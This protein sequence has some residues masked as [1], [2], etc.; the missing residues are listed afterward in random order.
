GP[1]GSSLAATQSILDRI[2]RDIREQLSDSLQNT[3]VQVGGFGG[4]ANNTGNVNVSLKPVADRKMSQADLIN[5]TRTLVKK[6]NSK[7]YS[8]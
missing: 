4:G 2:A 3:L 5:K 7:D 6:Y 1:Q 8:V